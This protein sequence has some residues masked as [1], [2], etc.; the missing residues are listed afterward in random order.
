LFFFVLC[1]RIGLLSLP[2]SLRGAARVQSGRRRGFRFFFVGGSRLRCRG[3]R[4]FSL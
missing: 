4:A 3:F 1:L 2:L